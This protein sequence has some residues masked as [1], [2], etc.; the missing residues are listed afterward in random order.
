MEFKKRCQ[1]FIN[2]QYAEHVS[3]HQSQPPV[4]CEQA[5]SHDH[6]KMLPSNRTECSF[7][8]LYSYLKQETLILMLLCFMC[9]LLRNRWMNSFCF[10]KGSGRIPLSL[11]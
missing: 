7:S 8:V 2:T 3:N 10:F 6:L 4:K 5:L 11:D 9:K 1:V